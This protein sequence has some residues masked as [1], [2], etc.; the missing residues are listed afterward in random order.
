MLLFVLFHGVYYLPNTVDIR[1]E[2]LTFISPTL[3]EQKCILS[4]FMTMKGL[5]LDLYILSF[6]FVAISQFLLSPT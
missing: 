3:R 2:T 1:S 5:V 4:S 6:V